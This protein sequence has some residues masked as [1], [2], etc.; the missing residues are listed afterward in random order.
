MKITTR[1]I[2]LC[3]AWLLLVLA[4]GCATPKKAGEPIVEKN[5]SR[6]V[7]LADGTTCVEPSGLGETRQAAGAVQLRELLDSDAKADEVIAKAGALKLK[8]EEAEAVYF[9]ACRAYSNA[10]IDKEAFE[11]DRAA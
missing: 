5:L 7:K 9:D 8:P 6:V 3:A 4:G 10:E 2:F 1:G 11:K